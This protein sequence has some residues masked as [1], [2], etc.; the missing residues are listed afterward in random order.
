[1]QLGSI[2]FYMCV[3]V[4][5]YIMQLHVFLACLLIL[6]LNQFFLFRKKN[7]SKQS[8]LVTLSCHTKHIGMPHIMLCMHYTSFINIS[9]T[10]GTILYKMFLV[11]A[12]IFRENKYA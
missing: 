10:H 7:K 5:I 2:A 4:H 8:E 6:N 3:H 1:M 11:I 12:F 9:H